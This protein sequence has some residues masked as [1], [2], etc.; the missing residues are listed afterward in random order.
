MCFNNHGLNYRRNAASAALLFLPL[1]LWTGCAS[2]GQPQPPSL[3]LPK[4]VEQ[5]TAQRVA[6]QVNLT[7]ITPETTTDGER[8]RNPL[9]AL[10]CLDLKPVSPP[11]SSTAPPPGGQ[12]SSNRALKRAAA[13]AAA[14]GITPVV[15]CNAV[16]QTPLVSV[17]PAQTSLQLPAALTVGPP[18]LIAYTIEL[19]NDRGH[20]AGLSDAAFVSAGAA[21]PPVGNLSVSPRRE[22]ALLQW[23]SRWT[24]TAGSVTV[25]LRRT[26]LSSVSRPAQSPRLSAK[27]NSPKTPAPFAPASGKNKTASR[28]VT[29]RASDFS[30][31]DPGGVFDQ[32]IISGGTYTYTAQRILKLTLAGHPLEVRSE[33]SAPVAF[34]YRDIFPPQPPSGLVAIPGGGFGQPPSIDLVWDAAPELDMLGYNIYRREADGPFTR[35]N[36]DPLPAPAYR[37]LAVQ[38]TRRYTYRITTVDQRH[39]ESAPGS[40]VQESLH[41]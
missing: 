14:T 16:K 27:S 31:S 20:A 7:W 4:P 37:D 6:D 17:G 12:R 28:E 26:L 10:V 38:P 39:N 36:P 40:E 30:S 29:L 34:A 2:P 41:Q 21:P 24:S 32:A 1:W 8:I 9:T 35:L 13:S 23:T 22:S 33:P 25:E 11:S 19:Q 18:V 3:H 5:L 15:A